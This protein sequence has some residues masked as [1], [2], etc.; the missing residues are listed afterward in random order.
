MA[1]KALPSWLESS[2]LD[3]LQEMLYNLKRWSED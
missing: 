2:P 3:A 1:V